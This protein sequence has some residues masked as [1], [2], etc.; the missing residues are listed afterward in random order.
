MFIDPT[1]L[2]DSRIHRELTERLAKM[3]GIACPDAVGEGANRP[4]EDLKRNPVLRTGAGAAATL[5]GV[6]AAA[7]GEGYELYEDT[8]GALPEMLLD[9]VREWHFPASPSGLVEKGS[10]AAKRKVE[11]GVKACHF[12]TFT[13]GLH[14]FQGSGAH[15][16]K[17]F[18]G[19]V[20]HW[21][22]MQYA[23]GR[24]EAGPPGLAE[25]PRRWVGGRYVDR[26]GKLWAATHSA[27]DEP[28]LW[29]EDVRELGM[30]T[31]EALIE[32]R[33]K[34]PCQC[35]GPDGKPVATAKEPAKTLE[36]VRA[37]LQKHFPGGNV[38]A[39]ETTWRRPFSWKGRR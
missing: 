27:A 20:G 39:G 11:A 14:P 4:D 30:R 15:Q 8:A 33:K 9:A 26:S 6:L 19:G 36:E 21:R 29:P 38:K 7:S 16:G 34:C 22:G 5:L 18:K 25:T 31:Y 13:E 28:S 2:W 37:F 10:A 24:E 23:G 35:P 17:R 32:F 3:A 12:K 1:G